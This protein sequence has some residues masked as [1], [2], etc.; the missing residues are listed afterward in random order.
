MGQ[1]ANSI[2][3]KYNLQMN[4]LTVRCP[5]NKDSGPNVTR[6]WCSATTTKHWF[7]VFTT[8]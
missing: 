3:F 8:R 6:Q 2:I 7:L 1:L 4:T 5:F